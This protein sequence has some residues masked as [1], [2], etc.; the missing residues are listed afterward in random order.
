MDR[1]SSETT[2]ALKWLALLTMTLDHVGKILLSDPLALDIIG[3]LALPLFAFLVAY[4]LVHRTR[5][6]VRFLARLMV[7][8]LIA[9]PIYRVATGLPQMNILFTLA[10][11][12]I[13]ATAFSPKWTAALPTDQKWTVRL[14]AL[15]ALLVVGPILEYGM[16][17]VAAVAFLA[18]WSERGRMP[19]L[20][21]AGVFLLTANAF[22]WY[23]PALLLAYPLVRLM[24]RYPPKLKRAPMALFY[25][26]YPAHLALLVGV[27]ALLR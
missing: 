14:L 6:P 18:Q 23:S 17:G 20:L 19:D 21:L 5:D 4:N 12:L 7:L 8:G 3:R 9:E 11:G 25:G 1:L 26:Y 22:V 24:E 2:E 15:T 13:L 10:F 16:A 27:R